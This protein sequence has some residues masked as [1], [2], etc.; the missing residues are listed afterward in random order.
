MVILLAAVAE[1][2]VIGANG[3]LPWNLPDDLKRF[4]TLTTGHTVIMGRATWESLPERF[5]PLP[6]RRNI[7]VT[8]NPSYPFPKD[9]VQAS[10]LEEAIT[11]A[12]QNNEDQIYVIGGGRIFEEALPLADRLEITHV[13]QS[14]E[15]DRF[16]PAID[17]TIWTRNDHA[18]T[19]DYTFSTYERRT[20]RTHLRP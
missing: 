8:R 1:N 9:V 7:V 2:G 6:N 5:R 10:S 19:S 13:K 14:P 20:A 12:T 17:P 16:F 4:R 18:E 15:G 3:A 11:L